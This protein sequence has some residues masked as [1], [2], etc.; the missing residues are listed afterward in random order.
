MER[1]VISPDIANEITG[2]MEKVVQ[3]G[4]GQ[5]AAVNGYSVA[6]KTGTAQIPGPGGYLPG[7]FISSFI[8]FAPAVNPRVA[9]LVMVDEPHKQYYGGTVAAPVFSVGLKIKVAGSGIAVKQS[10]A[11]GTAASRGSTVTVD[12]K[13]PA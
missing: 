2:L 6:G 10:P 4:T 3:A 7:K 11:P 13:A 5:N 9:V 12:F 8:G 1:Q